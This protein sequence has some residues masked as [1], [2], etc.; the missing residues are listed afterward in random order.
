MGRG[1][2]KRNRPFRF[3]LNHSK[4]TAANVYLLLY[5]KPS[6][7]NELSRDPK[8]ARRIWLN[9]NR[10][11]MDTLLEEGRVYG[12]GLYK[13][14]PRELANIPADDLLDFIP[15]SMQ[16]VAKQLKLFSESTG[17]GQ[18]ATNY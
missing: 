1:D 4:A 5:P 7:A 16:S 10:I 12:G 14:E 13:M 2:I 11:H 6:L 3:I 17:P 18:N 8:L 9:L 15:E